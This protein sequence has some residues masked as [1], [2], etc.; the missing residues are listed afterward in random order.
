M[1]HARLVIAFTLVIAY[2]ALLGAAPA[3]AKPTLPVQMECASTGTGQ[4][5]VAVKFLSPATNVSVY[6]GQMGSVI[7]QPI[8][9]QQSNIRAGE[10]VQIS[11]SF[12]PGS[13]Q[14]G[15]TVRVSGDFGT[16]TQSQV[17]TF[18]LVSEE[19]TQTPR[20]KAGKPVILLPSVT[21]STK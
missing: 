3:F 20:D 17:R 15:L 14:G 7:M 21:N 1:R 16:G 4:A 13:T 10:E 2:L 19:A 8:T 12:T 9:R 18:I 6:V 5:R 11:A